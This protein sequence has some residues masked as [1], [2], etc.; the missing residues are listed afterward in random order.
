[1]GDALGAIRTIEAE[2]RRCQGRRVEGLAA[3]EE[4]MR[5]LRPGSASWTTALSEAVVAAGGVG[6]IGRGAELMDVLVATPAT[7]EARPTRVVAMSRA[8]LS[9]LKEDDVALA[10]S[11]VARLDDEHRGGTTDLGARAAFLRARGIYAL[12]CGDIAAY[13]DHYR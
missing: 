9:L 6:R 2:A 8:V 10:E 1:A 13:L 7:D 12:H 4:A 5:A 3:A 11:L